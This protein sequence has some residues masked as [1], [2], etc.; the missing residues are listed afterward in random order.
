MTALLRILVRNDTRS[1]EKWLFSTQNYYFICFSPPTCLSKQN[2]SGHKWR[3]VW[4]YRC[5]IARM[6]RIT[7]IIRTS[8]QYA[9]HQ[10]LP[11]DGVFNQT[12]W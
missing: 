2:E 5:I 8:S 10:N 7:T 1:S 11:E 9:Y 3:N 4:F 12:G 6:H